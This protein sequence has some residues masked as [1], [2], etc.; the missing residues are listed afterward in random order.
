MPSM[1]RGSSAPV[2]CHRGVRCATAMAAAHTF[3]A[4]W[5]ADA[6][7]HLAC[8]RQQALPHGLAARRGIA[9]AVMLSHR[10]AL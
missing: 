6:P 3:A 10:P 9:R 5:S 8:R 2:S 4:G 7:E 1:Y